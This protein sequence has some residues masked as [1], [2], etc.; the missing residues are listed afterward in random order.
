MTAQEKKALR[1][2]CLA[3][4]MAMPTAVKQDADAALCRTI[5]ES[6][7]FR[8]A[9]LLLLFL[10]MRG[11]P[12][13]T[14]LAALAKA[15]GVA[16][17]YPRCTDGEMTFHLDDGRAFTP[18]RFGIAAPPPDAPEALP[19]E[20]TLCLLPGLAAGRDRTRLGYGGGFY[21]RYL[22]TFPGKTL[23]PVYDALLFDTLPTEA[24]DCT[25]DMIVTEKGEF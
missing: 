20:K 25:V 12:D 5:A 13:L 2:E 10:P 24:T 16:V 4:R 14:P 11:E 18:D 3:R 22:A 15:R 7:A 8:T 1:K 6:D 9:D 17:A 21:D 19:S 23:F